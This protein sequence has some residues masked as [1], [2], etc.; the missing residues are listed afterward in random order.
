MDK[1]FPVYYKKE[2]GLKNKSLIELV[3]PLPQTCA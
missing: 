2:L 3:P 1:L